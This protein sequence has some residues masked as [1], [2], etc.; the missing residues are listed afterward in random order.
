VVDLEIDALVI[1]QAIEDVESA[2]TTG[3]PQLVAGIGDRLQL[4]QHESRH[5]E[6]VV[7][8]VRLDQVGDAA[9]DHHAGVEDVGLEA[10]HFL[11]EFD[12]GNDE[13]EIV[14][15]LNE[16]A[17][18]DVAEDHAEEKRR[19]QPDASGPAVAG[20]WRRHDRREYQHDDVRQ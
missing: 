14:L 18:A 11:R 1:A 10:L 20:E 6:L 8:D 12:V 13:A 19:R 15:R 17:D 16:D 4:G 9:V 7:E 2:A 5:D 3:P